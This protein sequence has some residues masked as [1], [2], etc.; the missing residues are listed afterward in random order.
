MTEKISRRTPGVIAL[1]WP[2]WTNMGT[3]K[4]EQALLKNCRVKQVNA[5]VCEENNSYRT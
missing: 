1:Y 2:C 3:S 5:C 4:S